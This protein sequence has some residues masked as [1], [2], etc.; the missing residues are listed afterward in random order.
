MQASAP[1]WLANTVTDDDRQGFARQIAP[2]EAVDLVLSTKIGAEDGRSEWYFIRL[3]NG[4]LVLATYPC[5][6]TYFATEQWRSI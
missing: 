5:G 4:D 1:E 2:R 3:P 6:D